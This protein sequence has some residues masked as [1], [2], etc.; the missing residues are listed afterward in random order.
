[1]RLIITKILLF[2]IKDRVLIFVVV[3]VLSVMKFSKWDENYYDKQWKKGKTHT[4]NN[5]A[6]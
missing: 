1:M 5:R 3:R 4:I 2:L 6:S